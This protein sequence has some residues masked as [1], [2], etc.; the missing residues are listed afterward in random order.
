MSKR[1][2]LLLFVIGLVVAWGGSLLQSNPGYMD[3][4]YYFYGGRQLV[5][6][7]GFQEM[8]LWNYLDDPAGLP[9]PS[10]TYWMPLTSLLAA[11]GMAVFSGGLPDFEAAQ[12]VFVL[13]AACIPP[14]TAAL[15]YSFSGRRAFCWL[16]GLLA[17]F[18]GY[19]QAFLTTTDS[20]GIVMLLGAVFFLVYLRWQAAPGWRALGLGVLAG[21]MHLTRVDGLLWLAI[22]GLGMLFDLH[23]IHGDASIRARFGRIFTW[24]YLRLGLT[25]VGGYLLVMAPWYA[26]NLSQVGSL[27]APGGS[28][29]LWVR[30]YDELFSYPATKLTAQYWLSNGLRTILSARVEAL[31]VNLTGTVAAMGVMLPGMLAA[32]GLWHARRQKTVR[33]AFWGWLALYLSLSLVF[34]FS[35]TRGSY[36]HAGAAFVPLILAFTPAGI[37]VLVGWLLQ[38][39]SH[40]RDN[41]IRPFLTGVTVVFVIGFSLVQYAGS[42]IGTED[43]GLAWNEL[44]DRYQ[45]VEAVLL[46]YGANPD[47]VVVCANPPAYVVINR[48]PAYGI[49]DGGLDVTAELAADLDARWVLVEADSHPAELES[50]VENPSD[51]PPFVYLETVD[52]THIL[53][54]EQP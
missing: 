4:Y 33:L 17:L 26:R 43:G 28:R 49:P 8:L 22:A 2:Y 23:E 13:I 10:H 14:L 36:F 19:H 46:A 21:L 30:E 25:V 40:W 32:I 11:V 1:V 38:R 51:H 24:G 15:A 48:R 20:F 54:W 5:E 41:R 29:T 42:V 53:R 12:L 31:W 27:L 35:G 44:K 18:T 39:F 52:G 16:A 9:H 37:D 3:A 34:P 50:F 6:G 7:Q 47:D 45:A